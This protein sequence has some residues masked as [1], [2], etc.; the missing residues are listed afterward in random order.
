LATSE[1][2]KSARRLILLAAAA[3]KLTAPRHQQFDHIAEDALEGGVRVYIDEG[4]NVGGVDLVGAGLGPENAHEAKHDRSLTVFA[5]GE[6]LKV[7]ARHL[8]GLFAAAGIL[9][10]DHQQLS[11]EA[12]A[13]S[14]AID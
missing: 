11:Q 8:D 4:W 14:P 3:G 13:D 12:R 2:V 5:F 1:A 7:L 10:A 9:V 6:N